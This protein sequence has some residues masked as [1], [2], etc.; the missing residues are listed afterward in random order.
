MTKSKL[1]S[2]PRLLCKCCAPQ[3][4]ICRKKSPSDQGNG[5]V[6]SHKPQW[7]EAQP[8]MTQPSRTGLCEKLSTS[9]RS[10][11]A[12]AKHLCSGDWARPGWT[13][14][15][16][17]MCFLRMV[18]QRYS[19]LRNEEIRHFTEHLSMQVLC[20]HGPGPH[21]IPCECKCGERMP[22]SD[23]FFFQKCDSLPV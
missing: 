9:H 22:P 15:Q 1:P 16:V 23:T 19:P 8:V 4:M 12:P 20:A 6:V 5:P 2:G 17:S 14:P 7:P 18:K 11:S 21:R 3:V 10:P 13:S